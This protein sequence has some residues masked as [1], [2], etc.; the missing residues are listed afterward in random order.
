VSQNSESAYASK[1][2][3]LDPRARE[4]MHNLFIKRC[5][6]ERDAMLAASAISYALV[7][8]EPANLAADRIRMARATSVLEF[9]EE[10]RALTIA[11]YAAYWLHLVDMYGSWDAVH[12]EMTEYLT[13][14]GFSLSGHL[15]AA[16]TG[17]L[18]PVPVND[19]VFAWG[20]SLGILGDIWVDGLQNGTPPPDLFELLWRVR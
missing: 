10:L 13:V 16:Q 1:T 18:V 7:M 20:A 15:E 19:D 4:S 9:I 8:H 17:R 6:G 11:H 5:D 2:V 12:E 14:F 3:I